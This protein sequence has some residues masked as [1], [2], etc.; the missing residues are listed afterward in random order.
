MAR[1]IIATGDSTRRGG[2]VI[3]GLAD[4]ILIGTTSA[5]HG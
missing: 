1:R 5:T 3:S 2:I 4:C